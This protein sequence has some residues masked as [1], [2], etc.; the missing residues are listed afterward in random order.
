M[1]IKSFLFLLV[2][3]FILNTGC[4]SARR[5]GEH[6]GAGRPQTSQGQVNG[7]ENG[8]RDGETQNGEMRNGDAQN[9]EGGNADSIGA[10]STGSTVPRVAV[11]LGPGGAKAFAHVGVL[12]ALQQGRIPIDRVIGLE[13]GAL[14]G[15][16]YA[17][18]GQ[19]HDVEWKLYKM[20]QENI[21]RERGFFSRSR[22]RS[23]DDMNAFVRESFGKANVRESKVPFSCPSRSIWSGVVAWQNRGSYFDAMKYCLPFP[24]TLAAR[25]TFTA[26]PSQT[27]EA[28][29]LLQKEGYNLIIL[30]NVLGSA[31]PVPQKAVAENLDYVILWQEIKRAV[32]ET[33]RRFEVEMINVNTSGVA[34]NE[35]NSKKELLSLGETAGGRAAAELVKKYRF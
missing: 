35:F 33:P 10:A 1:A 29:E 16:L 5:R 13:W 25:G 22:P 4:Q 32:L 3:S 19:T 34:M 9:G 24:P 30:V 15:G 26:G 17:L 27:N 2:A 14:I 28:V 8:A 20:E 11:I 23:F 18:K 7:R 21:F 6:R 31:Q 12:K